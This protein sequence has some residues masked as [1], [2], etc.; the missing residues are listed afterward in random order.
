LDERRSKFKA[1]LWNRPNPEELKL[2]ISPN[3]PPVSLTSPP[4]VRQITLDD[5]SPTPTNGKNKKEKPNKK[6]T[7]KKE[8][9]DDRVLNTLERMYSQKYEN[10]TTDVEEV[11]FA[12][13]HCDIGGGSVSNKTRHSLARITL[14]WMIRECFKANTG[15]MFNS[16]GLFNIGLDPS[17]LYPYVA[18]RPP[19]LPVGSHRVQSPPANPIPIRSTAHLVKKKKSHPEV[20]AL[21]EQAR[22]PFLGTEE[23]EELNDIMSPKY[24]QLKIKKPWWVLEILPL[25]LR[26]QRGDS[27]WVTYFGSNMGRPRFI[28]KQRDGFKV[29]RSVNMRM[30][31][32]IEVERKRRKGKKYKPKPEFRFEPHWVD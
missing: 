21:L 32:E 31:A 15:I 5:P 26:Y 11:W 9:E 14:R 3:P 30:E 28:P 20:K 24:D 2:G 8:D 16:A 10:L 18:P 17:T 1:N 13:C 12:G 7:Y 22:T 6:K 27:Q 25:R 4:L 29:H 23:E 19:P